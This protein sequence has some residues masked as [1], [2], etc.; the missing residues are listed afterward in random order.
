[1]RCKQQALL[2]LMKGPKS[3]HLIILLWT[4][5][6]LVSQNCHCTCCYAI[7][8][9]CPDQSKITEKVFYSW[10]AQMVGLNLYSLIVSLHSIGIDYFFSSII[11][12]RAA[13]IMIMGNMLKL[14]N[15][16][17]Q[18]IHCLL[19]ISTVAAGL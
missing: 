3:F 17:L 8:D 18:Y 12:G 5:T 14:S 4:T 2:V 7:Q 10:I 6:N 16:S 19:Q 15:H 9:I 1:M 13:F 11:L